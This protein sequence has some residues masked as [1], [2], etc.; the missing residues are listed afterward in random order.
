MS[1]LEAD[2]HPSRKNPYPFLRVRVCCGS[3]YSRGKPTPVPPSLPPTTT[4]APSRPTPPHC[5]HSHTT[6]RRLPTAAVY[7]PPPS[8]RRGRLPAAADLLPPS[9]HRRCP[10]TTVIGSPAARNT[11]APL[12]TPRT[13]NGLTACPTAAA[14]AFPAAAACTPSAAAPP[15]S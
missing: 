6:C 4:H 7:P 8:T 5:P 9:T 2:P 10:P 1:V 13:R 14:A 11:P 3:G 12:S 15:F